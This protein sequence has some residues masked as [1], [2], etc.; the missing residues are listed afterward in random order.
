MVVRDRM[1]LTSF[2]RRT[3]H[4]MIV[5]YAYIQ[6]IVG[7]RRLDVIINFTQGVS[8]FGLFGHS[9]VPS[10]AHP[11]QLQQTIGVIRL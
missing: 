9:I 5:P 1:A 6:C 4:T 3:D 8:L 10:V 2:V 11:S 7:L